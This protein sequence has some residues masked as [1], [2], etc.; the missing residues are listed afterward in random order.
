MKFLKRFSFIIYCYLA[1]GVLAMVMQDELDDSLHKTLSILL[2]VFYCLAYCSLGYIA[3]YFKEKRWLIILFYVYAII[4]G[5]LFVHHPFI[6]TTGDLSGLFRFF[7][8]LALIISSFRIRNSFIKP[9]FKSFELQQ[10]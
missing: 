2:D 4:T 3:Y 8:T 1:L 7:I 5:I 10:L 6:S 9:Y